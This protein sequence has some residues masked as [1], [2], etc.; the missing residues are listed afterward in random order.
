MIKMNLFIFKEN[1]FIKMLNPKM[2]LS[3]WKK[4]GSFIEVGIQSF[5]IYTQ[6]LGNSDASPQETALLLHGFPESS[7][8]FHRVVEGLLCDF[9]R[10]V[11][12]DFVGFGWSDK[13]SKGFSY[14]L[15]EQTDLALSIWEKLGVQGGHLIAHD[16]G[17]S[18]ATEL[19]A[20]QVQGLIPSFLKKQIL[21]FTFTNG[22]IVL[23]LARLRITQKLLLSPW[24]NTLRF[25]AIYPIFRHQI[26]SAHGNPNL[27]EREIQRLWEATCLQKGHQK[28]HLTIQYINDRR[29]FEK[30][31]WL[32][33]LKLLKVPIHLC[34]GEDDAVARV[35]IPHFV[36]QQYC[37]SATISYMPNVGHFCQL[38][39]PSLWVKTLTDFY[40]T[41]KILI[42]S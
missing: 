41:H 1:R 4:K 16:M 6:E 14:S 36:K 2:A 17:N 20:R 30:F 40:K 10:I 38:D 9:K 24:G 27:E 34:W 7:F 32:P 5:R 11:L 25:I 23:E 18:I 21:S 29:R 22:S 3:E 15:M 37:P 8:S 39:N 33:A 31:R 42:S 28:N 26:R 12:F 19:A 13:P 35:Q